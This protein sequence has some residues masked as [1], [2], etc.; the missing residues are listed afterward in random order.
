M[1]YVRHAQRHNRLRYCGFGLGRVAVCSPVV[2][3]KVTG[4]TCRD[5]TKK[6]SEVQTKVAD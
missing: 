3:M 5:V 2:I 4:S 6:G 1:R